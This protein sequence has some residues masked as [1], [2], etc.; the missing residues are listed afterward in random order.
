LAAVEGHTRYAYDRGRNPSPE[1][2]REMLN[3]DGVVC[4]ETTQQRISEEIRNAGWSQF[5]DPTGRCYIYDDV[6]T[7]ESE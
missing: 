1:E 7:F 4:A 3:V 5:N 6:G 2:I